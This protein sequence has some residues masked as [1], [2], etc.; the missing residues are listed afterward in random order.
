MNRAGF[1]ALFDDPHRNHD[2]NQGNIEAVKV[3]LSEWKGH[4]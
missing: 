2:L 1:P 4:C 3:D